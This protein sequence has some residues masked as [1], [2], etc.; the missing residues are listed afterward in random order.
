MKTLLKTNYLK[1]SFIEAEENFNLAFINSNN[2]II[3]ISTT[4]DKLFTFKK[5]LSK[6]LET[7]EKFIS[8]NI[9]LIRYFNDNN[10]YNILFNDNNINILLSG[11]NGTNEFS[12]KFIDMQTLVY[13]LDILINNYPMIYLLNNKENTIIS[14]V[15]DITV[16]NDINSIDNQNNIP[17]VNENN[18]VTSPIGDYNVVN[19][20]QQNNIPQQMES[21]FDNVNID[22][23]VE[24][25]LG[26]IP[27]NHI[28]DTVCDTIQ[29]LLSE[30]GL[31]VK[32][33]YLIIQQYIDTMKK[34]FSAPEEI[35]YALIDD[36]AN[37]FNIVR[38]IKDLMD[39]KIETSEK[40][41]YVI[42]A[43]FIGKILIVNDMLTII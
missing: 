2:Q 39:Q 9:K 32:I 12:Y 17:Q 36:Y 22:K 43:I 7:P 41:K 23:L 40:M 28:D 33:N 25:C 18:I 30:Y 20:I 37:K 11:T 6:V 29:K 31:N 13:L 16:N 5:F 19:N 42:T 35:P 38:Q 21:E 10:K 4:I 15:P 3:N 8:Y 24:F 26:L 1:I 14:S 34:I 27:L